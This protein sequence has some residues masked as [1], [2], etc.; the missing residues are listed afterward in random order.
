MSS[1]NWT[2]LVDD[3]L[4]RINMT[5]LTRPAFAVPLW[6]VISCG[7]ILLIARHAQDF[8]SERVPDFEA[9]IADSIWF[10][11]ISTLTGTSIPLPE[12]LGANKI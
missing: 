8:W 4:Y 9:T 11:Y 12:S 10:A 3:F 2:A 7:W 1:D 5:W 6:A